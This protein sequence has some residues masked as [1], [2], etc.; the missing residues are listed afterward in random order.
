MPPADD[1]IYLG[2]YSCVYNTLMW[3]C[4][5]ICICIHLHIRVTIHLYKQGTACPRVVVL[6]LSTD[7]S[8]YTYT[9]YGVCACS[10]VSFVNRNVTIHLYTVRRVRV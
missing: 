7:V 4:V 9:R 3:Q 6:V 5:Y 2:G 8:Q 10:R 1:H